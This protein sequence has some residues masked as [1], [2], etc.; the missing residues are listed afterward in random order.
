MAKMTKKKLQKKII[1]KMKKINKLQ[2]EIYW[3][4]KKRDKLFKNTPPKS[5]NSS[6]NS[7]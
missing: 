7:V 2:E 1:K 3:L 6:A 4:A 5:C